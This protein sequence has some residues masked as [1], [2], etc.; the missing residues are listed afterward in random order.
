[1][2]KD[3]FLDMMKQD[4]VTKNDKNLYQVLEIFENILKDYPSTLNIDS[5]KSIE[6]CYKNMEKYAKSHAK[7]GCYCFSGVESTNF[8][9]NYFGLKKQENIFLK[10]E[11]FI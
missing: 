10:L 7:N 6:E 5:S 2:L 3:E 11:D 4:L 9:I 1:M 8:I